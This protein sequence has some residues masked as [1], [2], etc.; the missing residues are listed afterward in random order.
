MECAKQAHPKNQ[1]GA[2]SL[3]GLD[4]TAS[5]HRT[6]NTSKAVICCWD[7]KGTGE[8][9]MLQNLAPQGAQDV[10]HQKRG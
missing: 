3:V 9:E 7:L 5:P 4:I 8:D 2:T 1:F 6:L 10:F